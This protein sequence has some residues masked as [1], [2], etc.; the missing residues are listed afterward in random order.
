MTS[1]HLLPLAIVTKDQDGLFLEVIDA[2][3]LDTDGLLP[4]GA[5]LCLLSVALDLQDELSALATENRELRE[6]NE[7]LAQKKL[8]PKRIRDFSVERRNAH[9]ILSR[10]RQAYCGNNH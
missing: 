5:E 8:H 6:R 9:G 3:E 7:L 2:S 4:E 10:W 1:L